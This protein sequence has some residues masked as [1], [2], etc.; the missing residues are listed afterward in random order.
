MPLLPLHSMELLLHLLAKAFLP[1]ELASGATPL[2]NLAGLGSVTNPDVL[3]SL[4][5]VYLISSLEL[6]QEDLLRLVHY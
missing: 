1:S 2:Q 6:F 5:E 4:M 3:I